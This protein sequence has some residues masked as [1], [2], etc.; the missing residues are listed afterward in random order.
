[1]AGF[2][3]ITRTVRLALSGALKTYTSLMSRSPCAQCGAIWPFTTVPPSAGASRWSAALVRIGATP[4]VKATTAVPNAARFLGVM[5]GAGP[6]LLVRDDR[7]SDRSGLESPDVV[8][9]PPSWLSGDASRARERMSR[10]GDGLVTSAR[11]GVQQALR[12]R[13]TRRREAGVGGEGHRQVASRGRHGR[14]CRLGH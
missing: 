4:M 11:E 7:R 13:G 14:P 3:V 5:V 12:L 1:M 6:S 8:A 10:V 2:V 9:T